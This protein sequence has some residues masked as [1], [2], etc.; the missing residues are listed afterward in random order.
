[1]PQSRPPKQKLRKVHTLRDLY[2]WWNTIV[3]VRVKAIFVTGVLM[4]FTL[5]GF[6]YQINSLTVDRIDAF[7]EER[8]NSRADLSKILNE[9]VDLSDIFPGSE[10]AEQYTSSRKKLIDAHYSTIAQNESSEGA[11][12]E[13]D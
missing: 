8:R 11:C 9:I 7:C 2:V 13:L 6:Q 12:P 1:M 5:V 3:D 10:S 4:T